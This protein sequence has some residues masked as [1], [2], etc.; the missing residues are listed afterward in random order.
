MPGQFVSQKIVCKGDRVVGF[1]MLG[2]RWDHEPLLRW[3]HERRSLEWV[4]DHLPRP[5][6]T[7]SSCRSFRVLPEAGLA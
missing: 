7:R 4:L 2:S 1:N 6:S 5:S 3:I